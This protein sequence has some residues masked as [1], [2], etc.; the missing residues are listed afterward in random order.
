MEADD[1]PST[2]HVR[3]HDIDEPSPAMSPS[4]NLVQHTIL[5]PPLAHPPIIP[6]WFELGLSSFDMPSPPSYYA[7]PDAIEDTSD[8]ESDVLLTPPPITFLSLRQSLLAL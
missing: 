1:R 4:H 3:N 2:S 8:N 6:D 7:V 5:L